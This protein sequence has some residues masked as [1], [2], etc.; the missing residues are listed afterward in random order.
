MRPLF[1]ASFPNECVVTVHGDKWKHLTNVSTRGAYEFV[2]SAQDSV[3]IYDNPPDLLLH[4]HPCP[5]SSAA[6]SDSDIA[7]QLKTGCNWGIVAVT[8]NERGDVYN[9]AYPECW[10]PTI[11]VQ[12]LIGR[13]YL[14]GIRDC[15]SICWDYYQLNGAPVE[16]YPYVQRPAEYPEGSEQRNQFYTLPDKAGLKPV[17]R[18][19]RK[20][21]DLVLM[22]I[23]DANRH[24]HCAI[25]LGENKFLHQMD[26][27]LSE[28]W[29]ILNEEVFIEKFNLLFYRNPKLKPPR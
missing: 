28:E 29:R 23:N 13:E 27:R 21:G 1:G 9:I 17:A 4:S 7:A 8:G 11:P 2:L 16:R 10:G 15:V 19:K 3:A 12:P 24:N 6:A 22:Q 5:P 20:P 18:H 25:F 14:F 26:A